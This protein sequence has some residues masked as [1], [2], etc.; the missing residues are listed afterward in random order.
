[1][2]SIIQLTLSNRRGFWQLYGFLSWIARSR[3]KKFPQ[4]VPYTGGGRSPC[5]ISLIS[6]G[7]WIYFFVF[8]LQIIFHL[9]SYWICYLSLFFEKRS[10]MSQNKHKNM[11]FTFFLPML[12]TGTAHRV[13]SNTVFVSTVVESAWSS[14]F[15]RV[16][17]TLSLKDVLF[18]IQKERG[19]GHFMYQLV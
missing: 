18:E 13:G 9:T 4:L 3:Y 17:Q 19:W 1:M 10:S 7:T 2:C 6:E 8:A 16:I 12:T 15:S 14:S 11:C 5:N